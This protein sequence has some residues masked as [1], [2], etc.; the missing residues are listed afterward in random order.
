MDTVTEDSA[1][2]RSDMAPLHPAVRVLWWLEGALLAV[3]VTVPAAVVDGFLGSSLP[4]PRWWLTSAVA[5]LAVTGAA[6]IPVLRY[7]AFRYQLRSDDLWIRSGVF[8]RRVTV[9]PYIRLQFVDTRQG[10]L[11]RVLGLS[12][13][14]VH[15][16]AVG[17]SGVVP[18]L[19]TE[20]AQSLRERL[21]QLEGDTGGL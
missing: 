20:A 16:A 15:T 6:V 10:P 17:T 4:W 3:A 5:A 21:A 18:G 7:R 19:S 8:W 11:E 1:D 9:I 13:L 12:Q 14:V 2:R